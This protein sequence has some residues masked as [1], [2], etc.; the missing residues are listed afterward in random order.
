[1]GVA[2]PW[3]MRNVLTLG[4]LT[5]NCN[6]RPAFNTLLAPLFFPGAAGALLVSVIEEFATGLWWPNW[7]LRDWPP[8]L[9]AWLGTGAWPD[10]EA[11]PV[12]VEALQV[13]VLAF[14]ALVAWRMLRGCWRGEPCSAAPREVA[15]LA[16][17]VTALPVVLIVGLLRQTF[18]IDMQV[19]RW[20]ARY[21]P[22]ALPSLSVL[23]ALSWQQF[24]PKGLCKPSGLGLLL[25]GLLIQVAA[26][27]R[28]IA[29]YQ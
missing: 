24:V 5:F 12:L 26:S 3:Y 14:A 16:A 27:T 18:Y 15:F 9:A 28:L 17:V 21:A 20:A 4:S 8:L 2:A 6:V 11:F 13:V 7:L 29:F 19:A 1:M 25:V 23:L 10:V 22:V